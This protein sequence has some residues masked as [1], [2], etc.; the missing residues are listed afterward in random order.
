MYGEERGTRV[1]VGEAQERLF[2]EE[3]AFKKGVWG[4]RTGPSEVEEEPRGERVE[5]L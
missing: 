4:E 1:E 2:G 3:W 5:N